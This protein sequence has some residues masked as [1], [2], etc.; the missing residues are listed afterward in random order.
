MRAALILILLAACQAKDGPEFMI[1]GGGG[2]GGGGQGGVDAF[3]PLDGTLGDVVTGQ[4]CLVIDARQPNLCAT[5]GVGGYTVTLDG[6]TAMTEADGSFLIDSPTSSN[7][8]WSVTGLDIMSSLMSYSA[9]HRIPVM[10]QVDYFDLANSNSVVAAPAF[11]DVFIHVTHAGTSEASVAATTTPVATFATL[12]DGN[13]ATNWT[14]IGTGAFGMV[15]V[16]GLA[17]GAATATLTP[18]G[19]TATVVANIPIGDQTLTWVALQLP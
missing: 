11:G 3:V 12:F 9:V 7:I 1:G 10:K 6:H 15:W 14:Q 16:P 8:T 19:G 18:Q 4:V 2:G 13:A 5:T 17:Q